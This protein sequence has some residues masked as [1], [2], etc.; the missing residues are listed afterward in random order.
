MHTKMSSV[1]MRLNYWI[2]KATKVERS[3]GPYLQ[4]GRVHFYLDEYLEYRDN[5]INFFSIG[6][7]SFQAVRNHI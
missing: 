2:R 1:Q 4:Q 3:L 7:Q 5:V 6:L